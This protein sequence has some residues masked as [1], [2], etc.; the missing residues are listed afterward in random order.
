[1][2]PVR[3]GSRLAFI[4]HIECLPHVPVEGS[5]QAAVQLCPVETQ[6]N[7]AYSLP[8]QVRTD[9]TAGTHAG[10]FLSVHQVSHLAIGAHGS[11]IRI[12]AANRLIAQRTIRGPD[13]EFIYNLL[14]RFE[15]SLARDSPGS[16]YG[17]EEYFN[18]LIVNP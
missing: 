11:D 2:P 15:E 5:I 16:R 13:L 7:L 1:M 14:G 6:V 18:L 10:Y 4:R 3:Y 8:G 17:G 12:V 9:D